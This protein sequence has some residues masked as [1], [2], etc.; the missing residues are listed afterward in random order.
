MAKAEPAANTDEAA[1]AAEA[2]AAEA[3]K[4]SAAK[5]ETAKDPNAELLARLDKLE[6]RNQELENT[7][8]SSTRKAEPAKPD[9]GVDISTLIFTDPEKAVAQI[10]DDIT[11][12]LTS[13]YEGAKAIDKFFNDFYREAKD[14]DQEEDDWL[15]RA[16]LQ[17]NPE[18]YEMPVKAARKKLAELTRDK[19]LGFAKRA[20][21]Q[22]PPELEGGD[23]T[24]TPK[25][26][27]EEKK[28]ESLADQ[29]NARKA[30]R[31]TKR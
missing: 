19:M 30:A 27:K 8:R 23:N 14:L 12:S 17:Q 20:G 4:A 1:A 22:K 21:G 28:V 26:K 13:K 7:I 25:P 24:P 18:L 11:K 3:A 6:R 29:I 15:V 10:K 2:A 16:T 9:E 5:N 31:L